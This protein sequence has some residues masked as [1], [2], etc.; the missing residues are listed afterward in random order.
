LSYTHAPID[1]RKKRRG[2]PKGG[3]PKNARDAAL[4]RQ[5]G[6]WPTNPPNTASP[7]SICCCA[8]PAGALDK[9]DDVEYRVESVH[10]EQR[11]RMSGVDGNAKI[12]KS[13]AN[14]LDDTKVGGNRKFRKT[15]LKLARRTE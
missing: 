12:W 2:V 8:K 3:S 10:A 11:G 6:R 13:E 15:P 7:I 5:S 4:L 14:H 1:S 9:H